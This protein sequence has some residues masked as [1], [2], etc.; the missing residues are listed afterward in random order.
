LNALA[1]HARF[2]PHARE[3]LEELA[4]RASL[5]L[6]TNGITEVQRGR[7]GK[8]GIAHLFRAIIISEEIGISKPDPRFFQAAARALSLRANDLLC[9]GDNPSTD[10]EG[11][12][13]AGMDAC[14]YSRCGA[15]WPGPGPAPKY[16]ISDLREL[17]DLA[18]PIP[19]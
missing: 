11:A 2:L 9:I 5:C 14:W 6:I 3:V 1:S 10:I 17:I 13:A 7:I 16:V 12:A 4:T 19:K 18:P 8:A 15:P